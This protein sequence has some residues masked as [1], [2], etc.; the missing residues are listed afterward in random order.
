MA[1]YLVVADDVFYGVLFC[2]VVFS[3][4]VLDEIWDW[5]KSAPENFPTFFSN[6]ESTLKTKETI[7]FK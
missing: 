3:R 5:T 1:V 7:S 6:M 4:N 2:A